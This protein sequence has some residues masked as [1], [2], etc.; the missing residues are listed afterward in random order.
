LECA[1]G[2]GQGKTKTKTKVKVK[3]KVK[4]GALRTFALRARAATLPPPM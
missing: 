3:V 2:Q 4:V 1:A